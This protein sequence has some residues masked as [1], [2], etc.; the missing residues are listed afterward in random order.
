MKKY[1]IYFVLFALT[2]VYLV[3]TI[4]SCSS[5]LYKN[6][7]AKNI[8]RGGDL[9]ALSHLARF[10][11]IHKPCEYQA[12]KAAGKKK[13][14]LI[15]IGDS[16][17]REMEEMNFAA[18]QYRYISWDSI[19]RVKV[20]L[21]TNQVNILLVESVERYL[22]RFES[23]KNYLK[24]SKGAS[25]GSI[26]NADVA[27]HSRLGSIL[28]DVFG[29]GHF[30]KNMEKV[31]FG[32]RFCASIMDI[33]AGINYRLFNRT[34]KE[35]VLSPRYNMIYY[36]EEADSNN[37]FSSFYKL[38]EN[39]IAL[40]IKGMNELCEIYKGAGFNEVLFSIIP[41]KVSVV[42]PGLGN[43]NNQIDRI[44]NSTLLKVDTIDAY[45]MLKAIGRPAYYLDDTHW[46]CD[47][48]A[49]W[50]NRVNNFILSASGKYDVS[51]IP[52]R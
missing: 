17:T 49:A 5:F 9:Y 48:Q 29:I 25:A 43:Y 10:Y 12:K 28:E 21:D 14:R 13:V 16:F 15:I 19:A 34:A 47:G 52:A 1:F 33:K 8:Y 32:N 50:L 4:R 38:S 22:N 31:V 3:S 18:N 6:Y 35:V 20:N 27:T 39:S 44:Q 26:E 51:D 23:K 42:E 41:N 2:T 40:R 36:N 30:D 11:E 7:L 37:Y 46:N 24:V 45:R